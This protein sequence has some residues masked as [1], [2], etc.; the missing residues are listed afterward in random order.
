[1]TCVGGRVGAGDPV[2]DQDQGGPGPARVSYQAQLGGRAGRGMAAGF[3]FEKKK[4]VLK[5]IS[6][7]K[8]PSLS[9]FLFS[10]YPQSK[11]I[12]VLCFSSVSRF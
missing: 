7:R 9:E 6:K 2:C 5:N 1:M 12:T 11:H 8:P 3:M 4:H 10:S